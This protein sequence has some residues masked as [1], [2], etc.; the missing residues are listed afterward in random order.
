MPTVTSQSSRGKKLLRHIPN[1]I[2]CLLPIAV[3][4]LQGCGTTRVG[5][6]MVQSIIF[7][8]VLYLAPSVLLLA[9]LMCREEFDHQ[10]NEPE[11]GHPVLGRG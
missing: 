2:D 1:E 10:P 11:S 8:I 3:D 7:A 4:R 5:T 9:L 6:A